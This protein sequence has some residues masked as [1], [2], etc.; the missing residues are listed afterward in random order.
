MKSH[1]S[2][3]STIYR[4][5]PR[6]DQVR[7][8]GTTAQNIRKSGGEWTSAVREEGKESCA[9]V[10]WSVSPTLAPKAVALSQSNSTRPQNTSTLLQDTQAALREHCRRERER[11][12]H[13]VGKKSA[14]S[15]T[16]NK[17][18]PRDP[19]S[20]ARQ[21]VGRLW[22]AAPSAHSQEARPSITMQNWGR[23]RRRTQQIQ[24][25]TVRRLL[26]R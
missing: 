26:R 24:L 22:K 3:R 15:Y 25:W 1:Y 8:C 2:L 12:Q 20:R 16:D 21:I 14:N 9:Q 4:E 19:G 6:V 11:E 10:G 23:G 17:V 7:P 18:S 5:A 13:G